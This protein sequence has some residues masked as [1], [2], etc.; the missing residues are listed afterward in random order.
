M[1]SSLKFRVQSLGVG[2]DQ[3]VPPVLPHPD[4]RGRLQRLLLL[5]L[6]LGVSFQGSGLSV[7]D[8]GFNVQ[9]FVLSVL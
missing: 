9:I 8:V 5:L 6:C 3:A 1:V 4:H 7:Q 2:L